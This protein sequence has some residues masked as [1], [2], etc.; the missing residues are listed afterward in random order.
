MADILQF[1]FHIR[2]EPGC[3]DIPPPPI[4]TKRPI[5]VAEPIS[6][7]RLEGLLFELGA[8]DTSIT[9]STLLTDEVRSLVA[10]LISRRR[11]GHV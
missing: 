1:P 9:Y 8:G 7:W 5:I 3:L 6:Q 10:E 11:G 2:E 4:E